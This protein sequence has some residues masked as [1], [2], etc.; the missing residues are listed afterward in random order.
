MISLS[1]YSSFDSAGNALI[2]L[3]K[4]YDLDPEIYSLPSEVMK[5]FGYSFQPKEQERLN[6]RFVKAISSF[7]SQSKSFALIGKSSSIS[8]KSTFLVEEGIHKGFT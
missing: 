1:S 8:E 4:D 6:E 3:L 2:Q 5:Y 7:S